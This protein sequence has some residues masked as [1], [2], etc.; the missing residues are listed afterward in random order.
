MVEP[1]NKESNEALLRKHLL[2]NKASIATF[3]PLKELSNYPNLINEP[4]DVVLLGMGQDG[5]FASLFPDMIKSNIKAEVEAFN[6]NS[7]PLIFKTL[8][9]GNPKLSRITMNLPM[10]LDSNLIILIVNGKVKK[11][12]FDKALDN[13]LLPIHYLLAQKK[14]KIFVEKLF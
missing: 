9:I 7:K 14:K 1:K 12:V 2:I 4:F 5:H 6:I 3:I 13:K 8:P 11:L 10:I